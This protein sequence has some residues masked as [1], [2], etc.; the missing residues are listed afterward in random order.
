[1][2][3]VETVSITIAAASVVA[4]VIYTVLQVREQTRM[5]QTDLIIRLYSTYG[6]N[7]FQEALLKVWNA[8]SKDYEDHVKQYGSWTSDN[9]VTKAF[10]TVGIFFEGLGLLLHRKLID[11]GLTFDLFGGAALFLAWETMKPLVQGVRKDA[12]DPTVLTMFEYLYNEMKKK[13]AEEVA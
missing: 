9:P 10:T 6:S 4:G 3:D 12:D 11:P 7:E 8:H 2:V 13:S 5:R 1:L